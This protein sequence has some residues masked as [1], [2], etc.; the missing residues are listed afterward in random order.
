MTC[1]NRYKIVTITGFLKTYLYKNTDDIIICVILSL[2]AL[3]KAVK[4]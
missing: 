3:P 1:R 4:A 2:L